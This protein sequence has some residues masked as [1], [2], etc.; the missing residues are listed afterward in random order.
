MF[1][2]MSVCLSVLY[3]SHLICCLL[4]P[5]G[6]VISVWQRQSKHM[7]TVV[8][9]KGACMIPLR[10]LLPM[11][12]DGKRERKKGRERE[13]GMPLSGGL[14]SFVQLSIILSYSC[15]FLLCCILL[16]YYSTRQETG[17][18]PRISGGPAR[19]AIVR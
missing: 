18:T 9:A 3:V 7:N 5:C 1:V 12:R 4:S 17:W 16:Y 13:R 2:C 11:R 6:C 19:C 10:C 15:T 14:F 8:M